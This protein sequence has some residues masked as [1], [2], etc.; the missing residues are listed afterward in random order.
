MKTRAIYLVVVENLKSMSFLSALKELSIPRSPPKFLISDNGTNYVHASKVLSYIAEQPDVKK[1]LV[2]LDIQWK[3]IAAKASW[4]GSIFER[5]IG[6]IKL[7]INKMCGN[8][9]FT[10]EDFKSHL[11]DVEYVV[12]SRP[13]CR[14]EN[15]EIITPNHL[16]DGIG[17]ICGTPLSTP[18]L[19]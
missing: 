18:T 7:E 17:E 12:N 5:L 11:I 15:E 16:L 13:L 9:T 1:D 6:I 3:F 4:A 8:G 2:D 14:S 19:E 10:L